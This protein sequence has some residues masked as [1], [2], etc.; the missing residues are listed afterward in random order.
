MIRV[1]KLVLMN[2]IKSKENYI[3]VIQH[4]ESV[5]TYIR[6]TRVIEQVTRPSQLISTRNKAPASSIFQCRSEVTEPH[7]SGLITSSPLLQTNAT[8]SI[9]FRG[10]QRDL[11]MLR[12]NKLHLR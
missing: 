11:V 10:E 6:P 3:S 4:D 9:V 8:C 1:L 5:P 12:I 7:R 2:F